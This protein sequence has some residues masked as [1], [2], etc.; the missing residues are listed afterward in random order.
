MNRALAFVYSITIGCLTAC[1]DDTG[2]PSES[3]ETPC[4]TRTF[5]ADADGCLTDIEDIAR[6]SEGLLPCELMG[7]DRAQLAVHLGD[8]QQTIDPGEGWFFDDFSAEGAMLGCARIAFIGEAVSDAVLECTVELPKEPVSHP[9]IQ[10]NAEQPEIGSRC[11][12]PRML[13][14]Q[15]LDGDDLCTLQLRGG[16]TDSSMFCHPELRVCA[17][18]CDDAADCPDGWICD[19]QPSSG[20]SDPFC[21]I[22]ACR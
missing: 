11:D 3:D 20:V 8:N 12:G 17:L 15:Y 18:R 22:A 6:T 16:Q 4:P 14:D 2:A 9:D 13:R 19:D 7:S 21:Q 10:T 5:E 1:G